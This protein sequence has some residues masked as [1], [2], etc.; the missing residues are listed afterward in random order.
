MPILVAWPEACVC[1]GLQSVEQYLVFKTGP[2]CRGTYPGSLVGWMYF[3]P[4]PLSPQNLHNI[5]FDSQE[6]V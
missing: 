4:I 3:L 6:N 1:P 5:S 2:P